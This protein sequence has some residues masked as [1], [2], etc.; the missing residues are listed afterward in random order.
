MILAAAC[1]VHARAAV[2]ASFSFALAR[3][4]HPL[5]LD[6][7]LKD[8]AWAAGLVPSDGPW[9]DLTTRSP[10]PQETR[11]YVLYDDR[12]LYVAFSVTQHGI[13]IT[14]TQTTNDIGF[15][16][17]D[18]VGIGVDTS[19]AGS[20]SYFFETTPL[21]TRYEQ[22]NANVRFRPHWQSATTR[23]SQGWNAVLII[24]LDVL[25]VPRAGVQAWRF[26]FVRAIAARGDHYVWAYNGL[27]EDG[28][29]GSWPVFTYGRFWAAGTLRID[30][31]STSRPKPRADI[32]ALDSLGR[33][34][35]LFEQPN[36]TFLPQSVRHFGI[37]FSLP[38]TTTINFV[39]TLDPDFSNVEID[40]ETIAPQEFRRQ[41][42]EYRPFFAQGAVFVNALSGQRT[43]TGTY[44]GGQDTIFYSPSIGAF[45]RGAKVEGSFG[46]QSFGVLSFRGYDE[47]TGNEFDDQAFGYEHA[48][49]DN[50]FLYWTDGVLAH[51]SLYGDDSTIEGGVEA[52][53]LSSGLVAFADYAFENGSWVPQGSSNMFQTFVDVH[54]P[55][56]EVNL[57][58]LDI[59]PNYN[60]IDG[61][62][63]N[64]D[65]R[66]PQSIVDFTGGS[67]PGI[68]SWTLFMEA[69][70]FEDLSGAVH[71]ADTGAFAN[72]VFD[73]GLSIDGAGP[74][75]G[76]LRSYGIPSGPD[77]TGTLVGTSYFTGYPCYR[78]GANQ[79]FDMMTLPLDYGDAT[80]NPI[81]FLYS[82]GSFG[83][84]E[85]HLIDASLTRVIG[86][87][88]TLGLAYD[89]TYERPFSTGALDSQWLRRI[90]L[91]I[92]LTSES[93]FTL[94]LRS[95]NGYGGFATQV[96]TDLALAYQRRFPGGDQ[97]YINYGT[98]ASATTLDRLIVKFVFHA[99]ADTG[100]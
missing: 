43:T 83:G 32:Y 24:P 16:I 71:Q 81:D 57:G 87:R 48:L 21:A 14:A 39:G 37:D 94:A 76:E 27:M 93:S 10:A 46:D 45:D 60:P 78:D 56:Y 30:V 17:D 23:T 26:Q 59:A 13:P 69:D 65:I 41:L 98:P 68:K 42:V 33:D 40:Q 97:L 22:A 6:P 5:P 61:Y 1:A 11:A 88:F 90:S 84:N 34:R 63:A 7:S 35:D 55:N 91:G 86:T 75:I 70:R 67:S 80:P 49:Q 47:T 54:K 2:S 73:N 9:E 58:Y 28:A 52:R 66:G 53:N 4:E 31:A 38:L 64:S 8:P 74:S 95:I 15:G 82:W 19:G 3:A 96:G 51:H 89:G 72:V 36:Q 50:S 79:A 85:T 25:H 18:F 62:T 12:N 100:T 44:S 99:G 92:N 77:C 29:P 20:E